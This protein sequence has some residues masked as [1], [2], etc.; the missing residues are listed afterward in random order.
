V[1]NGQRGRLRRAVQSGQISAI[2]HPVGVEPRQR[3]VLSRD[4]FIL[5]DP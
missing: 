1:E 3:G 2:V 5:D 4:A